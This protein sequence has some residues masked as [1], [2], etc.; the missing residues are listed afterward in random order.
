GHLPILRYRQAE[1]VVEELSVPQIPIA[2]FPGRSFSACL[3]TCSPGDLFVILTDGL[4]EVFDGHDRE[5]GLERLKELIRAHAT[6]P[7]DRLLDMVLAGPR[8]HGQQIDDQ[9]ALLVRVE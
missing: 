4:V 1:G 2:M 9:T 5:F 6:A 3:A 7:R 8:Q